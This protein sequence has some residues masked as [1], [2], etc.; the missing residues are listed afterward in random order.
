MKIYKYP[1]SLPFS[2]I[3]LPEGAEVLTV[4]VQPDQG[5]QL[6]AIVDEKLGQTD[7]EIRRFS[8]I[9]TGH[10]MDQTY[11]YYHPKYISTIQL[12]GGALVFHVFELINK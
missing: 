5:I 8:V 7:K 12:N 6:W 10:S 3:L 4:Q 9:A 11:A 1:I 2:E